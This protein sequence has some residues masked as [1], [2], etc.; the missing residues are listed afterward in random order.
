MISGFYLILLPV[1]I[2]LNILF[3]KK[4]IFIAAFSTLFISACTKSAVESNNGSNINSV[5]DAS[6]EFFF[7][8]IT[9]PTN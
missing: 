7:G 1:F 4:I 5:V 6:M 2:I 8:Y 9:F 3:M